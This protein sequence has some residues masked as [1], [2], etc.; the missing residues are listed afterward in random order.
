VPRCRIHV[1]MSMWGQPGK[2]KNACQDVGNMYPSFFR[3]ASFLFFRGKLFSECGW[4]IGRNLSNFFS[5]K[6]EFW[7]QSHDFGIYNYNSSIAAG[8]SVLQ[9]GKKSSK[10]LKSSKLHFCCVVNFF[11]TGVV[12][13]DR[14]IGPWDAFLLRPHL[15]QESFQLPH[16]LSPFAEPVC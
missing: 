1:P 4:F 9:Q 10:K 8:Q 6:V 3:A 16:P 13:W 11:N 12:T 7:S 15:F 14:R 5:Q 2:Q